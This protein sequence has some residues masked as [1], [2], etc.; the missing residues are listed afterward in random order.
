MIHP[1]GIWN[2]NKRLRTSMD[3]GSLKERLSASITVSLLC[4]FL[5]LQLMERST[6]EGKPGKPRNFFLIKPVKLGDNQESF[7]KTGVKP[8]MMGYGENCSNHVQRNL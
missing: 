2:A 1:S 4:C 6:I 7:G 8:G 5:I 3:L